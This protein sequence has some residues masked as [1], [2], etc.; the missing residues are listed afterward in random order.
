[1]PLRALLLAAANGGGSFTAPPATMPDQ[2]QALPGTFTKSSSNPIISNGA[3][4]TWREGWV[5]GVAIF[6]DARIDRF[7]V[8]VGGWNGSNYATGIFYIDSLAD[9]YA[10]TETPEEEPTNPVFEPSGGL[11]NIVAWTTIQLPDLTYRAY[12][13]NYTASNADRIYM[14]TSSNLTSWTLQNGGSPVI[15]PRAGE[16]DETVVFDPFPVLLEDGT[17]KVIYAGQDHFNTRGIGYALMDTDGITIIGDG[18]YIYPDFAL[19]DVSPAFGA[20]AQLGTDPRFGIFHDHRNFTFGTGRS[21]DRNWTT[22]RSTF[23]READVLQ[24][25]NSGFDAVQVFDSAP[26][27]SGG[28]LYLLFC[29]G[30]VSGDSTGINAKVG[31]ASMAWP[32]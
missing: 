7:V 17:T 9:V 23:T 16:W 28:V 8:T 13:Q 1:V 6:R 10:G 19:G 21:I 14:A 22:D 29:G 18:F 32:S 11:S 31:I 27:W 30:N 24:P 2:G 20:P 15:A 25:D 26:M 5:D 3:G 4:G 12:F